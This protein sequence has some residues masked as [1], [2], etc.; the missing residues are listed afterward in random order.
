MIASRRGLAVLLALAV[1]LGVMLV[2]ELGRERLPPEDRALVP[3]LDPSFITAM[4]WD[5]SPLPAVTVIGRGTEWS[6]ASGAMTAHADPHTVRDVLA[7]LRG[8]R[9]QRTAKVAAAGKLRAQL[10]VTVGTNRRVIGIGEAL[11]GT[12]QTWL[13]VGERALLVDSW[14][15]RAL[16]PDPLALLDR[17][18]IPETPHPQSITFYAGPEAVRIEGTPRRQ[19][20]PRILLVRAALFADFIRALEAIEIV[21]LSRAPKSGEDDIVVFMTPALRIG[22][23]CPDDP[24]LAWVS[25]DLG[26]GCIA[27]ATYDAIAT[28]AHAIAGPAEIAAEPRPFPGELAEV[29]LPDGLALTLARTPEIEG[30]RA[31]PAA[32]AELLAVLAAPAE[33]VPVPSTARARGRITVTSRAGTSV[34]IQLLGNGLVR[35]EGEPIALRLSPAAYER[36]ARPGKAYADASVWNEEPTLVSSIRINTT[37]YTRGAVIGEW[38]RDPAG[39]FDPARVEAVVA[40]LAAPRR[41]PDVAAMDYTYRISFTVT[42]P[43]G[44]PVIHELGVASSR[45]LASSAASTMK[46]PRAVCDAL[47]ALAR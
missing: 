7:A 12:E 44:A 2:R 8:G 32:V 6:W 20:V 27:R 3:G 14:L 18:P 17:K 37:T 38:T 19:L 33:I 35:R 22:A 15:A 25:S 43:V 30:T 16:D 29:M 1:A 11:P 28:T 46:F 23:T 4:T 13:A 40:A 42:P 39:T 5:R 31:D 41:S 10:T 45:C 21:R 47:A 36:I 24:S 34:A 9:W 26:A